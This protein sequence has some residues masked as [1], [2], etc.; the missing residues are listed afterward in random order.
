MHDTNLG[1]FVAFNNS[2]NL[3]TPDT[4]V[5]IANPAEWKEFNVNCVCLS[6]TLWAIIT[7]TDSPGWIKLLRYIFLNDKLVEIN[8]NNFYSENLLILQWLEKEFGIAKN[9]PTNFSNENKIAHINWEKDSYFVFYRMEKH[10]EGILESFQV[11]S[12]RF[13]NEFEDYAK[14]SDEID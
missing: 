11:R 13:D 12:K 7:P 5:L 6:P 9:K 2:E 10:D 14:K 8:G 3:G 1:F 4:T